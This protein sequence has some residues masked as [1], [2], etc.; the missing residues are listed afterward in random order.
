MAKVPKLKFSNG[1]EIPQLGFGTWKT[2]PGETRDAIEAALDCG[3]RHIDCAAAYENE[4]VIGDA[5]SQML[6]AKK[7][8]RS[9]LYVTGKLWNTYHRARDVKP[10]LEATLKD[11]KLDYL[12]LYLM[13]WPM[14]WK[15]DSGMFPKDDKDN[16]QY[17]TSPQESDFLNTWK[18]MEECLDA[19][20]TK[21]IGVSNFNKR[22][23]E[24]LLKSCRHKPVCNQ[25]ELHPYLNQKKLSEY[26]RA[27]GVAV[28]AYSALGSSDRPWAKADDPNLFDDPTINEI[29]KKINRSVAQVL[30]R[31]NIQLGNVVLVKSKTPERIKANLEIFDFE[32]SDKDMQALNG[33]DR[34][35]RNCALEWVSDHPDYPFKDEY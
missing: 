19:G 33:L 18:A 3:Y 28:A 10:A 20:L 22:Q 4:N 14:A 17:T 11:L 34:N 27:N 2:Q 21:A 35:Q 16:I 15:E 29:A 12:D 26:C 31:W 24:R 25:I 13:H 1:Q 9:D 32:L 30:L 7:I 6:P 23:L 5:L 8:A